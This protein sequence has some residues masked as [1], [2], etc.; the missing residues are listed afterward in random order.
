M[1]IK[2]SKKFAMATFHEV[3]DRI[4]PI[5]GAVMNLQAV[6]AKRQALGH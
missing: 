2:E 5:G 3:L 1:Y 6:L 4:L